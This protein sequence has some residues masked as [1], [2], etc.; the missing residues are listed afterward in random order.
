MMGKAVIRPLGI[1]MAQFEVVAGYLTVI[2]T[3]RYDIIWGFRRVLRR[4]DQ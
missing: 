1:A 2:D 4:L 3:S